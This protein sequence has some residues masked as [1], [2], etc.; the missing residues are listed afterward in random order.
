MS[1][2]SLVSTIV[3]TGKP[4]VLLHAF[5]LSHRL[6]EKIEPPK[7]FQLILPDFPGFGLSPLTAAG[8]TLTDVS[9]ALKN[10]LNQKGIGDNFVLGGISMGGYWAMEFLRQFPQLVEKILFISTRPGI[11]KP[12]ARQNRLKMAERVEKQGVE[13]LVDAMTP[14]LL[15]K[16]TSLD[17]PDVTAKVG[18]WIREAKPEAVALAQRAM[19]DRRDQ[20]DLMPSLKPPTLIVAGREDALIAPTEAEAMAKAIPN[21]RLEIVGKVGHL[22][23]IEAPEVFQKILNDFLFEPT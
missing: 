8:L 18:R 21:N 22:V 9:I 5:P 11:D 7:G 12:D 6:W 19:A 2:A 1:S 10:H 17:K 3:G 14:G 20:T 23:P 15:G 4:I 13:F 16:S